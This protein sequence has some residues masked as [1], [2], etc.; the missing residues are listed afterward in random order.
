M[1]LASVAARLAEGTALDAWAVHRRAA[2]RVARG[3][4]VIVLSIGEPDFPTPPPV[5][6]AAVA[7]LRGGRTRYTDAR[8]E[9]ALLDALATVAAASAGRPIPPER[10]AFFPGAQAA[11]FA[12]LLAVAESGD[13]V[14]VPEPAYSTYEGVVATTGAA[15]V[16]VPL[17]PER[18]FHL[19]ADDVAARITPRTRALLLNNPHNPTGAVLTRAELEALAALCRDHDL[20]L[21]CDEVYA[22]LTYGVE[23]T[24]VLAL[25]GVEDRVAMLSSLS[26]SHA[27]TGF[28]H[29]WAV[30][31]VPLVE[32]LEQLL[33]GML[34]G[35]PP[36]V[37]DAG[38]AALADPA[39][40]P[41]I[42][43]AYARRAR[44]VVDALAGAPGLR[45]RAPE[46]GMFM[47][48]DVRGSGIGAPRFAD[49]LLDEE[50]VAVLP[51]D[52]FGP[53]GVG[54]L[55]MSLGCADDQLAEACARIRRFCARH[56]R[57]TA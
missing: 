51:L 50:G 28:R 13:E 41:A 8:G 20:W 12:V 6:E 4:D 43:D 15:M 23:F 40:T 48:V 21:I 3:E 14:L 18:G 53:G 17:R 5:V 56:A 49:L 30:G 25:A 37:Q 34:F 19:A 38:L 42:R 44:L 45:A 1:R 22:T 54:H 2:G 55:R 27:M 11:L 9:P 16:H 46:G 47:L 52:L 10:V 7:S 57:A 33:Q 29:G 36:F 35:C 32:T 31:P 26:K 24:S 39:V